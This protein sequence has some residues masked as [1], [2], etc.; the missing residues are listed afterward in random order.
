LANTHPFLGKRDF[1]CLGW[2]TNPKE[3][4]GFVFSFCV[5]EK[6]WEKAKQT[7]VEM[8]NSVDFKMALSSATPLLAP[9]VATH[10]FC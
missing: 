2:Y 4:T 6:Y 10:F 3:N 5:E 9:R 8:I 1:H 7:F